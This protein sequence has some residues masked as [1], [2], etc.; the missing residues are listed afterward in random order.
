MTFVSLF[1][2]TLTLSTIS[3]YAEETPQNIGINIASYASIIVAL[4]ALIGTFVTRKVKSPADELA[5]ADFAYKKI[6]ER[7]DEVNKDR[8]YLQSVIN[9]LRDQLTKLDTDAGNSLED[10]RKLRALV[11]EGE[12]RIEQLI[13]ENHIL[14]DRLNAIAEKV[15]LGEAITLSDVYGID[16]DVHTPTMEEIEITVPVKDLPGHVKARRKDSSN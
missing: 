4:I 7:L 14:H 9:A 3:V 1:L 12:L 6:S 16:T 2:V 5:R 8:D 15:R 13:E 11:T 10:R